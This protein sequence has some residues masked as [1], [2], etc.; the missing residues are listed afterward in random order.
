MKN[1]SATNRMGK[2]I[3]E[4]LHEERHDDHWNEDSDIVT[5][6]LTAAA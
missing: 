5:S 3:V 4:Q 6:L 1:L 2:P